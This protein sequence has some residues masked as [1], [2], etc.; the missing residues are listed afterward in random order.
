[1][2]KIENREVF[3]QDA[4]NS[5]TGMI[6]E[7]ENLPA[8]SLDSLNPE[9]TMVISIDMNNGFAKKGN[10]YSPRVEALIPET[11][12]FLKR[13]AAKGI[14]IVAYTDNH[15][16]NSPEFKFYSPHCQANTK[17]CELISELSGIE[18]IITLNKNSTNGFL[19]MNPLEL[20]GYIPKRNL[21]EIDTFIISGDCTD[22]CLKDYSLTL[23]AY[24]N[25]NNREARII[26]PVNL[27][28]TY[29]T[30]WHNGDLMNVVFL[31]NMIANGIEV[32]TAIR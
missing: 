25:E 23:R 30:P 10:L 5:L 21:D 24:F 22:L 29:D 3:L 17:E 8:V 1:M 16:K 13:C 6:N 20:T 7:L 31:N 32:V 4:V 15:T 9:K 2:N 11:A 19:A 28:D 12:S 18:G 26:V 14:K 27:V